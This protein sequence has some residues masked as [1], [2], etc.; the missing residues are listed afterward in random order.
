MSRTWYWHV[1]AVVHSCHNHPSLRLIVIYMQH[2]YSMFIQLEVLLYVYTLLM[3]VVKEKHDV[4]LKSH[5]HLV[6]IMNHPNDGAFY[7]RYK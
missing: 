5:S 6:Y 1:L 4:D 2:A 7:D 3:I